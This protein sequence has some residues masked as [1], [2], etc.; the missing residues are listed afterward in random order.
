MDKRALP[1]FWPFL[2]FGCFALLYFASVHWPAQLTLAE[3]IATTWP[4]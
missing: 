3:S 4:R 2:V 1:L